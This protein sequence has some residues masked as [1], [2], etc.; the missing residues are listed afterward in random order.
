M[1]FNKYIKLVFVF[2]IGTIFTIPLFSQAINIEMVVHSLRS[3]VGM[4]DY[5]N[6]D[7]TPGYTRP[8]LNFNIS[9]S[10]IFVGNQTFP[11]IAFS[12]GQPNPN[13]VRRFF[14]ENRWP[15][16]TIYPLSGSIGDEDYEDRTD[17]INRWVS[18]NSTIDIGKATSIYV[19]TGFDANEDDRPFQQGFGGDDDYRFKVHDKWVPL[20]RMAPYGDL[21]AYVQLSNSGVTATHGGAKYPY[22][23]TMRSS[24]II[25]PIQSNLTIL[26]PDNTP[27]YTFCAGQPLKVK[28]NYKSGYKGGRFLWEIDVN[29]D[30]SWQFLKE[31][32]ASVI[33][34]YARNS[35]T[36]YR[37]RA[38]ATSNSYGVRDFNGTK[39]IAYSASGGLLV[40]QTISGFEFE[41]LD[42][43]PGSQ[44]SARL[45]NI[46]GANDGLDYIV[47]FFDGI[48]I[49]QRD[50]IFS[51]SSTSLVDKN[52]TYTNFAGDY[53]I[54]VLNSIPELKCGVKK[55]FTIHESVFPEFEASK[56]DPFC[57]GENGVITFANIEFKN[58]PPLL[59]TI[60]A[61]ST[62]GAVYSKSI[63]ELT[64][65]LMVPPG[66]YTLSV[67]NTDGCSSQIT[68]QVTLSPK[69]ELMGNLVVPPTHQTN[70]EDYHG[71]CSDDKFGVE[72]NI[73]GG[74]KPY[75][76]VLEK[77][78]AG[79][80]MYQLLESES[81]Y[82]LTEIGHGDYIVKVFDAYDC[83]LSPMQFEIVN[84]SALEFNNLM[85]SNPTVGCG[86][87]NIN[88]TII[89][90][91]TGGIPPYIYYFNRQVVES[92]DTSILPNGNYA[93]KIEDAN[94]CINARTIRLFDTQY[95]YMDD[96]GSI[97]YDVVPCGGSVN[98]RI[99]VGNGFLN[100]PN[101]FQFKMNG[102]DCAS[103]PNCQASIPELDY[104]SGLP[105]YKGYFEISI[106][107]PGEHTF[108]VTDESGCTLTSNYLFVAPTAPEIGAVTNIPPTC[109][110]DD[111]QVT[112]YLKNIN[113]TSYG[114]TT[115]I[116]YELDGINGTVGY[117]TEDGT[118]ATSPII[119][120]QIT[121]PIN[122]PGD[123]DII[124]S[125]Y[126]NCSTGTAF[127]FNLMPI[128]T[129]MLNVLDINPVN[130]QGDSTGSVVVE[131]EGNPPF[132]VSYGHYP[133]GFFDPDNPDLVINRDTLVVVDDVATIPNLINADY[134]ISATDN[135][136]CSVLDQYVYIQNPSLLS[137]TASTSS[138]INCTGNNGI[139][140]VANITGGTAPYLI[141]LNDQAFQSS[142]TLTGALLENTIIV[143]DA[144]GCTFTLTQSIPLASQTLFSTLTAYQGATTCGLG[145]AIVEVPAGFM[146]PLLIQEIENP[147]LANPIQVQDFGTTV[148]TQNFRDTIFEL[149]LGMHYFLFQDGLGCELVD[150]VEV[151]MA[152]TLQATVT[153]NQI[154][155]CYQQSADGA[156]EITITGGQ[157][158]YIVTMDNETPDTVSS[159]ASYTDLSYGI[160]HFQIEDAAG[161][162]FNIR[163]SIIAGSIPWATST[164]SDLIG[165]S[166][167]SLMAEV[168]MTGSNGTGPFTFDWDDGTT[169]AQ[170]T[171][172]A[173]SEYNVTV[174]D[175]DGCWTRDNVLILGPDTL[176]VDI[177]SITDAFCHA[178]ANGAI[179]VTAHGGF[180]PYSFS[181]D[182]GNTYQLDSTFNNL[183]I[184]DYEIIVK[185]DH[186]CLDTVAANVSFTDAL[187]ANIV[188]ENIDCNQAAN[189]SI[190][191]NLL[192]GL[193]PFSYSLDDVNYQPSNI[194][195]GL[196]PGMYD[197]YIQDGTAC[198][199]AYF[200][201]VITQPSAISVS[202]SLTNDEACGQMN[203]AVAGT[204]S[205]GTAPLTYL[206]NGNPALNS[207][208][209][210]NI[211]AGVHTLQVTDANGCVAS[212]SVTVAN[213]SAPSISVLSSADEICGNANG[214]I[215][216]QAVDGVG[217]MT[218]TWSH[219][220]DLNG[221]TAS[222]LTAGM[223]SVTVTDANNCSDF[224][225][226]TINEVA[227]TSLSLVS[228]S[229]S[230]CTDDNGAITLQTT[231]GTA[232]MIFNWS[233]DAVLNAPSATGLS[234]GTYIVNVTDANGCQDNL[235]VNIDFD[236][237]PVIG[238]PTSNQETCSDAN[239]NIF[240]PVTGGAMPYQYSW[241]HDANLN[242]ANANNLAGGLYDVTVTDNLGCTA[243]FLNINVDSATPPSLSV[244][245]FVNSDCLNPLGSVTV[246]VTDGLAP[247]TYAWSHDASATG[248]TVTD[249]M[250][251]T[252]TATVTDSN[253][254]TSEV[255]Q[256]LISFI[257]SSEI[258]NSLE[259]FG[260]SDASIQLTLEGSF[261]DYTYTWN[262]ASIPDGPT[263]SNLAAG[264]YSVTVTNVN[265]C[266]EVYSEEIDDPE[267]IM[268]N[269]SNVIPVGCF[270]NLGSAIAIPT[271][272]TGAYSYSWNDANSGTN[273][274][275]E[276]LSIGTY[277]VTVSDM[278]GCSNVESIVI[279]NSTPVVVSEQTIVMPLCSGDA[280]GSISTI[281]SGGFGTIEYSWN[282]N[283]NTSS[284][285]DLTAGSYSVTA[286]DEVA[287]TAELVIVLNDPELLSSATSVV[288]SILCNGDATGEVTVAVDGGTAPYEYAWDDAQTQTQDTASSLAAGVYLV[289]IIDANGC[290]DENEITVDEPTALEIESINIT[291]PNCV[292]EENGS[293]QIVAQGGTPNYQY[294][295][296]AG[297]LPNAATIDNLAAANYD[298]EV[299]DANGCTVSEV[300]EVIDPDPI[301]I[302]SAIVTPGVC[303]DLPSGMI[304]VSAEGGDG[305]LFY[306]WSN[307]DEGTLIENLASGDYTVTVTDGF[308]CEQIEKYQV[309]SSQVDFINLGQADTLVCNGSVLYYDFS[310][311]PFDTYSWSS[312]NQGDL[313]IDAAYSITSP[314]TYYFSA[315]NSQGCIVTDTI[316]VVYAAQNLDAF[317]IAP[318]D[319]VV[320]DT[321]VAVELTLPVPDEINWSY[322]SD[323]ID[324]VGQNENQ[325]L[326]TFSEIGTFDLGLSARLGNC[327]SE[328]NKR[329]FVYADSTEIP[330]INPL[331]PTILD[332]RLFPNPSDGIFN[333]E[334]DL[335]SEQDM[336]IDIFDMNSLLYDRAIFSGSKNYAKDYNLTLPTGIYYAI[337][338]VAGERRSLTLVIK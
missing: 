258:T 92:I 69:E 161:C 165:C 88:G 146:E 65:T 27:G 137:A 152:D 314:D 80:T 200:G 214:A 276:N 174:T 202:T 293:I 57:Y 129:F 90:G 45:T 206:W 52:I 251:G 182:G 287:C 237:P 240:I 180:K 147:A 61:T 66:I 189:G 14:Y 43:C 213:L 233:H 239:G 188:V 225:T 305:N 143:K 192:G 16:Q 215:T 288:E 280:N 321:L 122:S 256:S 127:D 292:G 167:D 94:G 264:I 312:E 36:R 172:L 320:G 135:Y 242:T 299:V 38:M 151:L 149:D 79:S 48:A 139:I 250:S 254:C 201:N 160:Y 50:T 72:V 273:A 96:L 286:T 260:D 315:T 198:K 106:D 158:P 253:G 35:N 30:G 310:S 34:D 235:V 18:P 283:Q 84:P 187:S 59:H 327:N 275:V 133:A 300:I 148:A 234:A 216:V 212:S 246:E 285:N 74:V 284:I 136:G 11:G 302:T 114:D 28:V 63:T 19:L 272:G 140:E 154:E 75:R 46:I 37:V 195:S 7:R 255:S 130:C 266:M 333:L 32:Y 142:T 100:W 144:E 269:I 207:L 134:F 163:D 282:T 190:E 67:E 263:A 25:D 116:N 68:Y 87:T 267:Q 181:I 109:V 249:L 230:L 197:V 13:Y 301:T 186:D 278:F 204:A 132:V 169:A 110:G 95:M 85:F 245:S 83:E 220:A 60:T 86:S 124:I 2:F 279:E 62:S 113:E 3:T 73:S 121:V 229:N 336:V 103:N 54:Q 277:E 323:V 168:S 307:G 338:Q 228:K 295:W 150:S 22:Y 77:A 42:A 99:D 101:V 290:V 191:I 322:D 44:G 10:A 145:S 93:I 39:S 118:A 328:I 117:D 47:N 170:K 123:H 138:A 53:A 29:G 82:M 271:G 64:D 8:D 194:F 211:S 317:F 274:A 224:L 332:V 297:A 247:F 226:T 33:N 281:S 270:G 23:V 248:V 76:F 217:P 289:Q 24:Y 183:T 178:D 210:T 203:G 265:G 115:L 218:Y 119:P 177:N 176:N 193:A 337:V 219:D 259:C 334:V 4:P 184:G 12:I 311:A 209:L 205:G 173:P 291:S 294:N 15:S 40:Q 331:V 111:Y 298:L 179:M 104:D 41:K 296:N 241:S 105:L 55:P 208:I 221:I 252:Y 9:R 131:L 1:N 303:S 107:T 102:I 268:P 98:F 231:N 49:V 199:A 325:Y 78:G 155:T 223:Y 238:A 329:I 89:S 308:G 330:F 128:D 71:Y 17:V 227:G 164:V 171:L 20:S 125:D 91:A 162:L 313:T 159:I 244:S 196:M 243:E 319:I 6:Y 26:N 126:L 335:S 232:P 306:N 309:T 318:T 51:Y 326:F 97:P 81:T 5:E 324:F 58:R 156:F 157:S 112:F 56:R 70:G 262:D 108:E 222:N 316:E 236:A 166:N 175:A 141:A 31:G 304:E 153:L 120:Y 185:D 257:G 21:K 261:S